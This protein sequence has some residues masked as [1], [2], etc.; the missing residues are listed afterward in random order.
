MGIVVTGHTLT[1]VALS[2]LFAVANEVDS[3][4]APRIAFR[5]L[6]RSESW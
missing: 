1:P 6:A 4:E 5:T 3:L 2:F